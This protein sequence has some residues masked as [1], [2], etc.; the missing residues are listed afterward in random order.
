MKK[1]WQI[2][3]I[4]I[5]T[6]LITKYTCGQDC[7]ILNYDSFFAKGEIVNLPDSIFI[8]DTLPDNGQSENY[9]AINRIHKNQFKISFWNMQLGGIVDP[10]IYK[11]NMTINPKG[12]FV[13]LKYNGIESKYRCI[14][15]IHGKRKIK[16]IP[17]ILIK[18][19]NL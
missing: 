16:G 9:S 14:E 12:N 17:V 1:I 15:G 4:S 2:I 11:Y 8:F 19:H 13:L 6:A 3:I 18:I 5:I 10:V 7:S